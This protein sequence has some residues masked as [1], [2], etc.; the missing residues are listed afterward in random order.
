MILN[1]MGS[2]EV[3]TVKVEFFRFPNKCKQ[4]FIRISLHQARAN[5]KLLPYQ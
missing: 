5:V 1:N 4:N 3:E 2:S